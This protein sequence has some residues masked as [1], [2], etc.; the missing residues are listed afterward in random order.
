MWMIP[1]RVVQEAH[2]FFV[3]LKFK[4]TDAS[5]RKNSLANIGA[6]L[7]RHNM[8]SAHTNILSKAFHGSTGGRY[9][10]GLGFG[11]NGSIPFPLLWVK[12]CLIIFL[13]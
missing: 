8:F 13:L 3:Y 2:P 12:T 10:L 5:T 4:N 7:F 6:C 1:L 11:I 9:R